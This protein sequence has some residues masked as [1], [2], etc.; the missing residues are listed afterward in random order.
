M[1]KGLRDCVHAF[2]ARA[3]S[4]TRLHIALKML[5]SLSGTDVVPKFNAVRTELLMAL[6]LRAP[7]TWRKRA[8][9]QT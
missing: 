4:D 9:T 2:Q 6:S 5:Q 7:A 1:G 3:A 8:E